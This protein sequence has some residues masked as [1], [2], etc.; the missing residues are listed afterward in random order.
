MLFKLENTKHSK[1]QILVNSEMTR[2]E[3]RAQKSTT[4]INNNNYLAQSSLHIK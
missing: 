4:A 1:K 2:Q 3:G